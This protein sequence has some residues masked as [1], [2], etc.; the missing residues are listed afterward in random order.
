MSKPYIWRQ[1]KPK[2]QSRYD[3]YYGQI[4]IFIKFLVQTGYEKNKEYA[5]D[6]NK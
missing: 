3:G 2:K 6:K 5:T 1:N 4:F